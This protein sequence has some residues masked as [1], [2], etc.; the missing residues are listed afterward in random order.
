VTTEANELHAGLLL[1]KMMCTV[2]E[3]M[4]SD[5]RPEY[6]GNKFFINGVTFETTVIFT[7]TA[8]RT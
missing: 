5:N 7:D 3:I 6:E 2:Y 4:T 1:V 8:V